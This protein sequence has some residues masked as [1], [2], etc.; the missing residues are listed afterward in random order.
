MPFRSTANPR[1]TRSATLVE[2]GAAVRTITPYRVVPADDQ[3]A[4]RLVRLI[5]GRSVDAV[6]FTS[7][8]AVFSLLSAASSLDKRE[9]LLESFADST[10]AVCIGIV[11]SAAARAAGIHTVIEPVTPRLGTMVRRLDAEFATPDPPLRLGA[12]V[13]HIRG[14]RIS[15]DNAVVQLADH[16]PICS[17]CCLSEPVPS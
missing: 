11:S 15:V 9:A 6:T 13:I 10:F 5:T 14:D 3:T 8:A 4:A 12:H 7:A 1:R 2:T 16:E 17:N